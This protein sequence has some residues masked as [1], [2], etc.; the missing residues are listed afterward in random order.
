[1]EGLSPN[2]SFNNTENNQFEREMPPPRGKL[3]RTTLV[4]AGSIIA[5]LLL[6][7]VVI[8]LSK[9][10]AVQTGENSVLPESAVD[11]G[12]SRGS[13]TDILGLTI[14]RYI[15]EF[16]THPETGMTLYVR[17][18]GSDCVNECLRDFEPYLANETRIE[19]NMSTVMRPDSKK[20]QYAWKGKALYT[21]KDDI[22]RGDVLGDGT[23]LIWMIARP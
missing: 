15:G 4:V 2:T 9:D 12:D 6:F 10:G 17:R 23:D 14:D 3:S 5:L 16:F 11:F 1:M 8:M 19:G 21:H 22:R 7:V 18:D 13:S 20:L